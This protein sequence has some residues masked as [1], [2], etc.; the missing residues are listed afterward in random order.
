M[1][2]G[3]RTLCVDLRNNGHATMF[4]SCD[5]LFIFSRSNLPGRRMPPRP[6]GTFARML[7]CGVIL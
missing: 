2:I 4:Y 1:L 5:L 3:I 6:R 7:E